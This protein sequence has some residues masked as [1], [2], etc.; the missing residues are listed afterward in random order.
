MAVV[1]SIWVK[2][3]LHKVISMLTVVQFVLC[4]NLV[5]RPYINFMY[6]LLEL[7]TSASEA[8]VLLLSLLVLY[9]S[10]LLSGELVS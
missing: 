6:D 10:E 8:W 3:P 1:I 2:D 9:R 5:T 7:L 4:A